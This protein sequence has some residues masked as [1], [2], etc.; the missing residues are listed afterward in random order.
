MKLYGA[1]VQSLDF[2]SNDL[3]TLKGLEAF[4]ELQELVLDN[5]QLGDSLALP[6]LPK[7]HT[8]SLNKN[9][10]RIR[11]QVLEVLVESFL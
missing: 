5:N 6:V 10:V 1:K 8:L 9:Q 2:S 3:V 7:L 4:Q 11:T